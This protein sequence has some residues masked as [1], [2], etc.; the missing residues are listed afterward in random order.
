VQAGWADIILTVVLVYRGSNL[1]YIL[2]LWE[3][4][5]VGFGQAEKAKLCY[6]WLNKALKGQAGH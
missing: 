5:H 1:A 6:S 2:T 4:S 3:N